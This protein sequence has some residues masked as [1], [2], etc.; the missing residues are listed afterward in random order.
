[1]I[2]L[3]MYFF[4]ALV[5][6]SPTGFH[7]AKRQTWHVAGSCSF[8]LNLLCSI[9]KA[10]HRNLGFGLF[11]HFSPLL[12]AKRYHLQAE[13]RPV[14]CSRSENVVSKLGLQYFSTSFASFSFTLFFFG[15]LMPQQQQILS[16]QSSCNSS[17]GILQ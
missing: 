7:L 15:V 4:S 8:S 17:F 16:L 13:Q 3:M 11:S 9:S 12:H 10:S 5:S 6:G 14:G 1:M 2:D